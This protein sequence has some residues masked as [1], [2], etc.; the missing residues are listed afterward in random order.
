MADRVA[1]DIAVLELAFWSAVISS[2]NMTY[3]YYDDCVGAVARR[4]LT[5]QIDRGPATVAILLLLG[6][7]AITANGLFPLDT[8]VP[9]AWMDYFASTN[10]PGNSK[11]FLGTSVW[12][13]LGAARAR[14]DDLSTLAG[15]R[16]GR[17][18]EHSIFRSYGN[19]DYSQDCSISAIPIEFLA[20]S[21]RCIR[22]AL[23]SMLSL[24]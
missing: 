1:H 18:I 3:W 22:A 10:A 21:F 16:H 7:L 15:H 4:S 14:G 9:G 24:R 11:A 8:P 19:G 5:R 6:Q 12:P 17:G 13:M 2:T 20:G 23:R